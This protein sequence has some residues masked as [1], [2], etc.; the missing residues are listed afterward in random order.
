LS[1]Y[2]LSRLIKYSFYKNIAF[3]FS[4]F[5][6]QFFNGWS[7]QARRAAAPPRACG[8]GCPE[9]AC[10]GRV[11]MLLAT[12]WAPRGGCVRRLHCRTGSW[13]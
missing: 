5:F 13:W 10:C 11:G 4:F 3:S 2:R 12:G 6:Y 7:G 1:D 8:A 9:R